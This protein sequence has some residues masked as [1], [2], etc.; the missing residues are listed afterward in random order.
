[1]FPEQLVEIS[2]FIV[3]ID[4]LMLMR[5]R[6]FQS[7]ARQLKYILQDELVVVDGIFILK[8]VAERV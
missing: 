2:F 5:V 8:C 1:M 3:I 6:A 4:L 7:R